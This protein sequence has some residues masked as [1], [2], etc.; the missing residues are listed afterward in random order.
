M[1]AS[2]ALPRKREVHVHRLLGALSI[3]IDRKR[4]FVDNKRVYLCIGDS[5][6]AR[7]SKLLT[8]RQIWDRFL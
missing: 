8:S 6:L 7:Y 5:S 3:F 2:Y 1:P 4:Y